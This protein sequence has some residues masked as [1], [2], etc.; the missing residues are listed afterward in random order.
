MN[1]LELLAVVAAQGMVKTAAPLPSRFALGGKSADEQLTEDLMNVYWARMRAGDAATQ[2][3]AESD[4]RAGAG[5]GRFGRAA[6]NTG[7]DLATMAGACG[8]YRG[9]ARLGDAI[10]NRVGGRITGLAD[11]AG[12]AIQ[13]RLGRAGTN[14]EIGA[15]R[16]TRGLTN[17]AERLAGNLETAGRN[18]GRRAG[19]AAGAVKGNLRAL[20]Y[21]APRLTSRIGNGLRLPSD[22]L[23]Q[24]PTLR[25]RVY[26]GQLGNQAAVD[27]VKGYGK[28]L[29]QGTKGNMAARGAA[30]G[31]RAGAAA[32][33]GVTRGA[34]AIANGANTAANAISRGSAAAGRGANRALSAAGRGMRGAIRPVMGGVGAVGG[35]LLANLAGSYAADRIL[36]NRQ[37]GM[38]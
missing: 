11:R 23:A 26:P 29:A 10:A 30:R 35:G 2:A 27:A 4:D 13:D 22:G 7:V 9:G 17:G 18:V 33:R 36:G 14:L 19:R 8:G 20:P 6:A 37:V 5:A 3:P 16:A 28:R 21:K 1:S 15:G 34:G 24:F 38:I 12:A 25:N 32:G 31:A